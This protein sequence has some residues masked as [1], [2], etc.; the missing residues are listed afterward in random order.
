MPGC[1]NCGAPLP[2]NSLVCTYCETR[3]SVDLRAI[4]GFSRIAAAGP[5][6]PRL[7]PC[8][9]VPLQT[10]AVQAEQP[11][12]LE[13][14]DRCHGLFFDPGELPYLIEQSVRNVFAVDRSA[15]ASVSHVTPRA[16]RARHYV[17]CPQ[18][19]ELMNQINYGQRS[20]IVV[21]WCKLHGIWLDSGELRSLLEWAKAGGTLLEGA[22]ADPHVTAPPA[23]E[24]PAP[25]ARPA[26]RGVSFHGRD[27]SEQHFA[28]DLLDAL[29]D[30]LRRW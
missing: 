30:L 22:R 25:G 26:A 14:C 9:D 20:G 21:D 29:L 5:A 24:A 10:V 19:R 4:G 23:P 1:E 17:W 7:C 16:Q 2:E 13:R 6:A 12:H 3:N 28:V 8:C 15:L 11:V 27:E 18:C